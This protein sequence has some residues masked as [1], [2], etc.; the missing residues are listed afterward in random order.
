M[1]EERFSKSLNQVLKMKL[2]ILQSIPN[3][4]I[5]LHLADLSFFFF[6]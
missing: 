5:F 4:Q 6:V 1:E 2:F 3:I